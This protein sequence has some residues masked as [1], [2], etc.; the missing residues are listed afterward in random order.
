M[1]QENNEKIDD[2]EG[3]ILFDP[4]PLEENPWDK[5]KAEEDVHTKRDDRSVTSK[6]IYTL[7]I[8][9]T[10]RLKNG[11]PNPGYNK[12]CLDKDHSIPP[13]TEIPC[14]VLK[15]I[16]P[17]IES[18]PWNESQGLPPWEKT[19]GYSFDGEI[20]TP[21]KKGDYFPSCID[22]FT[23]KPYAYCSLPTEYDGNRDIVV[24]DIDYKAVRTI[25]RKDF[26]YLSKD[27][28]IEVC[29]ECPRGRWANTMSDVDRKKYGIRTNTK[30]PSCDEHILMYCWHLNLKLLF[31]IYFKRSSLGGASNFLG[32]FARKSG[33]EDIHR[34]PLFR[35]ES[36]IRIKQL[37]RHSIPVISNTGKEANY[38]EIKPIVEWFKTRE[39]DFVR[40]LS[41][42]LQELKEAEEATPS[43]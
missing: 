43:E 21:N 10:E 18:V 4:E 24:R 28:A 12:L 38:R 26:S 41:I 27:A 16:R 8:P 6:E 9:N 36:I 14:V 32:S 29:G 20:P 34:L 42:T 17:N 15:R 1:K 5:E 11:E 33:D 19:I 39:N 40:N 37:E 2:L 25:T 3:D 31:V 22:P 23:E 30:P 35:Y 7:S 13:A